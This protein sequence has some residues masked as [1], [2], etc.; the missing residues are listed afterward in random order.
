M[1]FEN[2]STAH[3]DETEPDTT[4]NTQITN[5]RRSIVFQRRSLAVIPRGK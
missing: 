3:L 4:G 1:E 5:K 2:S